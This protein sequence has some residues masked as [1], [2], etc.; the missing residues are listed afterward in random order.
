MGRPKHWA[1]FITNQSNR[2]WF[3]DQIKGQDQNIPSGLE[4]LKGKKAGLFSKFELDRFIEEEV[5]HDR[6]LLTSHT[7]QDLQSFSSGERKKALLAYLLNAK[8]DYLI[9]DNPFD[10]LDT[11]SQEELKTT[12]RDLSDEYHM[13]QLLSRK[14][15]LLPFIEHF[16]ILLQDS[17]KW[18][19]HAQEADPYL[20]KVGVSISGTIPKP[21]EVFSYKEEYLVQL[22]NVHVSYG[23][24]AVLHGISWDIK[25]G[26]FWELAGKNGSGKTTILS[27]ITGDNPKAYGK[28]IY[29][30]GR[31]KGSGES[32]WEIKKNIGYFTPAMVDRFRGYHSLENMLIS[33]ILDSIGLYV[34]PSE[35]H[36]RLAGEWLALVGMY[37]LKDTYFHDLSLGQQRLIMCIRAMIKHPPLLILD[38][39]TAGLDDASASFIVALVNKMA[40]ESNT[41]IIFVSH[42]KEKDL[43]PQYVY[44]LSMSEK[45]SIGRISTN[46]L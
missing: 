18:L 11:D 15:D 21:P 38:E 28:D 33:G 44:Q 6:K 39:P 24:K 36:I 40:A 35:A 1:I 8:P 20:E 43:T 10:N 34:I 12:L 19:Q 23:K 9:L 17:L 32:I 29:L 42:R 3:I 22:R 45:G 4:E 25:P 14:A 2:Q 7:A 41:T 26:E 30:F 37:S 13:I 5:R 27:M 31:K 16:G 46:I